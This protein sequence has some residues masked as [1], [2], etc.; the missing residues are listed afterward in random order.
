MRTLTLCLLS[1]GS[2]EMQTLHEQA[3]IGTP[4]DVPDPSIVTRIGGLTLPF[5][6]PGETSLLRPRSLRVKRAR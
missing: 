2:G 4:V 5:G 6:F 1:R 3:I